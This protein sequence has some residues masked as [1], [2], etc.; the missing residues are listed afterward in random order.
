[1][2]GPLIMIDGVPVP[3]GETARVPLDDGLVRGDGVFEGMRQYGRRIRTTEAHLDRM[4]RS[5][6][7]ISLPFDR[8]LVAEE[9]R[10][11]AGSTSQADCAIR[12]MLTRGGRRILREEPLPP[13]ADSW[14]LMAVEHRISPLLMESKTLSYAANMQANRLARAAGF[15]EAL[16]V[17]AGDRV[18]LEAPTSSFLWIEGGE[19]V[20]PPLSLGI[21]DSLTRRLVVEAVPVRERELPVEGLAGADGA[22]LVSSVLESRP[23]RAV[24]DI[25][26]PTDGARLGEVRRALSEITLARLS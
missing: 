2:S 21:L 19:V 5:C 6:R 20:F 3:G 12:L 11:F 23:V 22:L 13:H 17:R 25:A 14:R 18:V 16:M 8:A 9:L 10:R 4:E 26:I 24:G 1:M 7:A 15:D